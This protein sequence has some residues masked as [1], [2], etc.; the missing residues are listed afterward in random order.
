MTVLAAQVR[1][2]Q[3]VA[4]ARVEFGRFTVLVGPSNSGKSAFL[5]AVRACLRNTAVP[6]NVRQG[7]V[8]AEIDVLFADAIVGIERGKS[9]STYRLGPEIFTKSGRTVPEPVAAAIALPLIEGTDAT[10]TFQFDKPF[11][12][13][14]PGSTAATVI[15][16]LTNVSTLHAAV[17]E[18]NRRRGEAAN[19]LRVRQA[20]VLRYR[21]QALDFTGLTRRKA[22][23]DQATSLLAAAQQTQQRLQRLQQVAATVRAAED[24][25]ER[26][27]AT[28]PADVAPLLAQATATA[29][30]LTAVT[31]AARRVRA[32]AEGLRRGADHATDLRYRTE[33]L[34][35]QHRELLASLGVCPTCGACTGSPSPARKALG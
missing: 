30:R 22:D 11:L 7:A 14:E 21:T 15:G 13:S 4:D 35:E 20:D 12:L 25:L 10:F 17:R 26:L 5:R 6:A 33:Q 18:T 31:I 32:E 8:K 28:Q 1:N 23:L 27:S 19:L 34:E 16:S 29:A 9:L 3:S 2:F 24:A